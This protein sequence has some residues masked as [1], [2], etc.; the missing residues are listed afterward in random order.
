MTV[1]GILCMCVPW[2]Y[3]SPLMI[4]H[5]L[6]RLYFIYATGSYEDSYKKILHTPEDH[7][8]NKKKQ[9]KQAK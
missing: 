4:I 2:I 7:T 9:K 5:A 8:T 3:Q 1:I 6:L